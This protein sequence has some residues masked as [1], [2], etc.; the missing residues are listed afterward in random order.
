M[1]ENK[2]D[3]FWDSSDDPF[4]KEPVVDSDWFKS[5]P[6]SSWNTSQDLQE[7]KPVVEETKKN[8][9]NEMQNPYVYQEEKQP[10]NRHQS[11]EEVFRRLTGEKTK[12]SINKTK[13]SKRRACCI[14]FAGFTI[15][16]ALFFLVL[17]MI[18]KSKATDAI[19]NMKV[20]TV[21]V[22][23][24]FVMYGNNEVTL[25]SSAYHVEKAA[26]SEG[27]PEDAM[28]VAVRCVIIS[29]I[30]K[31][32]TIIKS[33]YLG[34]DY[35]GETLY[36]TASSSY[37]VNDYLVDTKYYNEVLSP[38]GEGNGL[39]SEGFYC[40]IIPKGAENPRIYFEE[41]KVVNHVD[42]VTKVFEK[43]LNF[44]RFTK[45]HTESKEGK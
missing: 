37:S 41:T 38:Y 33:P 23:N 14:G 13:L 18:D 34:F 39:T 31:R 29:E 28:L 32:N 8:H 36:I 27:F 17:M 7:E 24:K 45:E 9:T 2:K 25:E 3:D 35:E 44:N 4:W 42:V 19:R 30:Y 5:E 22:E 6:L 43:T 21:T 20:E 16:C 40:F 15:L 1:E 10:V 26:H 11:A 12:K